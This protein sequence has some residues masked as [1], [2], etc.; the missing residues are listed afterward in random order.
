[1]ISSVLRSN[2]IPFVNNSFVMNGFIEHDMIFLMLVNSTPLTVASTIGN[3]DV[4][5][6]DII[7]RN[8]L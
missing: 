1:M 2:T 8:M 4:M 5:N 6:P 7:F 3:D